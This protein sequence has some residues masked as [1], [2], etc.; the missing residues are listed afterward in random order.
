MAF[1][2][3]LP[4][5]LASPHDPAARL[6]TGSQSPRHVLGLS[7]GVS[8]G[9]SSTCLVAPHLGCSVGA[10]ATPVPTPHALG[11]QPGQLQER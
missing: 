9:H 11:Q 5:V 8:G 10:S 4:H 7:R 2:A 3:L 1:P 6:P